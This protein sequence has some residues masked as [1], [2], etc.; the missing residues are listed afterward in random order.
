[1]RFGD[2]SIVVLPKRLPQPSA[3]RHAIPSAR[4]LKPLLPRTVLA[5][6]RPDNPTASNGKKK[7][8]K[9]S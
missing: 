2:E 1:V 6:C 3:M 7:T 5:S 8:T 9:H 4:G